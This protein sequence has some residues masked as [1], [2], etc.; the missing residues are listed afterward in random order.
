MLFRSKI[1]YYLYASEKPA[2]GS[3]TP[4]ELS[5]TKERVAEGL[6]RLWQWL[7]ADAAKRAE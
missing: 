6:E 4:E 7:K 3:F 1:K 2:S 5:T